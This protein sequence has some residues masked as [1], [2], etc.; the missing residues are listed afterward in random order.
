MKNF[1]YEHP[2]IRAYGFATIT[3]FSV[4]YMF[5]LGYVAGSKFA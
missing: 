2:L 3:A 4:G 1:L 5:G